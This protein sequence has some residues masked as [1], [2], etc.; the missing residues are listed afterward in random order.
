MS[1]EAGRQVQWL[2]RLAGEVGRDIHRAAVDLRPT[3]LDDLGLREALATL[4]REWSLRHGIRPD[5]EFTGEGAR[6]PPAA[7]RRAVYRIVQEALTN[8]LKHA[9][10]AR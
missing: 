10:A 1:A 9:Q 7:S 6:L 2:Q 3:A 8:I 4:L 5:L